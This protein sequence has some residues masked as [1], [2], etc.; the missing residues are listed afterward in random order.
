MTIKKM[1]VF[2]AVLAVI[3]AG[4]SQGTPKGAKVSSTTDS[5]AY[6]FGIN[7]YH[8][9]TQDSVEIDPLLMAKGH[10][11]AKEN[12][13]EMDEMA[14]RTF[15]MSYFEKKQQADMLRMYEG[16]KLEGEKF[17]EENKNKGGV[18][19]TASGLQ[20]EV[21]LMGTGPKPTADQTVKVHY[22]GSLIDG[23]KFDSSVDR[24]E[25]AVFP[26]TGVIAGWVEALQLMPVGSKFK[27]YIPSNLAY[28]EA[29]AGDVITPFAVLIFDVELLEIVQ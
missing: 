16:V 29:G 24:N 22:T 13:A 20:Y 12:T 18:M 2:A 17:L 5:L 26:V 10:M 7:F 8:S 23:T 11:E 4:C 3:V 28:G 6:A 21:V 14:A 9:I 27:L 1:F 15:I 19:T 25:P